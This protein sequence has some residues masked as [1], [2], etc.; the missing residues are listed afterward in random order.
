[1]ERVRKFGIWARSELGIGHDVLR[2][3]RTGGIRT[4]GRNR[5]VKTNRLVCLS[6]SLSVTLVY[7]GQTVGRINMKLSMGVGLGPGQ[8]VLDGDPALL[9]QRGTAP[10]FSAMSVVAERLGGSRSH[11][12]QS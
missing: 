3:F 8:T 7:C 6:L 1:M 4:W 12:I 2:A 11:L 5:A 10:Q 9:S